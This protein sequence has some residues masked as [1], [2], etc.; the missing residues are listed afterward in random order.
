MK[1]STS[2]QFELDIEKY[3]GFLKFAQRVK[4]TKIENLVLEFKEIFNLS[5]KREYFAPLPKLLP[6]VTSRV[7]FTNLKLSGKQ[8][9]RILISVSKAR[10][11]EL[12]ECLI[13]K[14]R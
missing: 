5:T 10:D 9:S 11:F 13:P 7:A 6:K 1:V 8:L 2:F 14:L 3:K 4:C 12:R